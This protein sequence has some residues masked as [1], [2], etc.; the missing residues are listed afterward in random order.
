MLYG[1]W[2]TEPWQ[3]PAAAGGRVPRNERG[4]VEVPPFARALPP[5]TAHLRGQGLGPVARALGL[6]F[7]PAIAG[8]ELQGGRMLPKLE[9]IVV[10][11]VGGWLAGCVHRPT[12]GCVHRGGT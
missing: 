11:Q 9:G 4:N 3:P 7:A 5:G 8:F 12:G 2:Q 6:D 1:H 10:C